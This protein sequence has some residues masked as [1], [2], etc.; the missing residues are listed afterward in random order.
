M[1]TELRYLGLWPYF[2]MLSATSSCLTHQ[3]ICS[4]FTE[5]IF[6]M[7]VAQLPLPITATLYRARDFLLRGMIAEDKCSFIVLTFFKRAKI[8]YFLVLLSLSFD[9]FV[10]CW[11]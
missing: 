7:A 10:S 1:K 11:M 2:M 3:W 4:K 6:T 8:R 5:M 9:M